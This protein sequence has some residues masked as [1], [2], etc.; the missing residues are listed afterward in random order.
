MLYVYDKELDII[1]SQLKE[2]VDADTKRFIILEYDYVQKFVNKN[3]KNII[4][5]IGKS[6]KTR[7][8]H[9]CT[10]KLNVTFLK[11]IANYYN[12]WFGDGIYYNPLGLWISCNTSWI[13]LWK[14][15]HS[16]S[17]V[18]IN[19]WT[20]STYIYE[21]KINK[22]L[23]L[24]INN[25]DEFKNFIYKYRNNDKKFNIRDV[26]DWNRLKKEYCGII[27]CP[28]LG[29]RLFGKNANEIGLTGTPNDVTE[30]YKKMIGP[31]YYDHIL[32][33]SEWYRHWE[34]GTGVIWDLAGIKKIILLQKFPVYP[35]IQKMPKK[36]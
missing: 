28:Y 29:N 20:L 3:Y 7:F 18:Q 17:N 34:A 8:I 12:T 6:P 11:D 35:Y 27:I 23:I 1:V 9:L 2:I 15:T 13:D 33:L 22:S 21:I 30:F 10:D 14:P 36:K 4:K 31:S 24:Q 19:K 25:F 32:F 26:I 5:Y 16:N